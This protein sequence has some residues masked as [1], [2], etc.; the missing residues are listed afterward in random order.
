MART[1]SP[2]DVANAARN[3]DV[4]HALRPSCVL[5]ASKFTCF[6]H[7]RLRNRSEP[8]C[9]AS[10][11]SVRVQMRR[12][13]VRLR[14]MRRRWLATTPPR[15]FLLE[16]EARSRIPLSRGT[17]RREVR[18]LRRRS[19]NGTS[20]ARVRSKNRT[21]TVFGFVRSSC[22]RARIRHDAHVRTFHGNSKGSHTIHLREKKLPRG[23]GTK[24]NWM[25]V[26]FPVCLTIWW[27]VFQRKA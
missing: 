27:L 12:L 21:R 9:F 6:P 15:E 24:G 25:G 2:F 1:I 17:W 3:V 5:A 18:L 26:L 20:A 14:R 11:P 10:F 13:H 22:S 19:W 7:L 4:R 23:R 8:S 16:W